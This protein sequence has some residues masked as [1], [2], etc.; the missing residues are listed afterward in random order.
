LENKKRNFFP[1]KGGKCFQGANLRIG[2]ECLCDFSGLRC[3]NKRTFCQS[4]SCLNG[5][6]C[7]ESTCDFKCNW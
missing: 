6:T 1:K 7:E 3:E 5:G 4:T 2:C